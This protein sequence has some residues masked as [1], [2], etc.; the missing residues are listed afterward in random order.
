LLRVLLQNNKHCS[1]KHGWYISLQK[2]QAR[3]M[4]PKQFLPA[5][6]RMMHLK[7]NKNM[8]WSSDQDLHYKQTRW[9]KT[10]RVHPRL[11]RWKNMWKVYALRWSKGH[12]WDN[13]TNFQEHTSGTPHQVGAPWVRYTRLTSTGLE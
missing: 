9:E 6:S 7:E 1:E 12:M 10:D 3:A 8:W 4:V 11:I 2:V 13:V 5:Y